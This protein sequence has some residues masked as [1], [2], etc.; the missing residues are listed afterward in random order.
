MQFSTSTA[1]FALASVAIASPLSPMAN[2]DNVATGFPCIRFSYR[3]QESCQAVYRVCI[4]A[5][6]D[7][8][9]VQETIFYPYGIN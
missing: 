1:L 7:C 4:S 3:D 9:G 6:S 5:I 2:S 8:S